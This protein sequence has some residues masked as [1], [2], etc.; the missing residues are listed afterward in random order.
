[1]AALEGRERR[2]PGVAHARTGRPL[3]WEQDGRDWP[4]RECSRF[5]HAGGLRWHVQLAGQGPTL[6]LLHGTGAA[7]HSWRALL[8]LLARHFAVIAPDLPGHGFTSPA[9][10]AARSPVGMA[11][12]LGALL[13]QLGS[14]PLLAVGHSAGAALAA[15]MSLDGL[16]APRGLVSLNGAL[17]PLQG[18]AGLLFPPLARTFS[19]LPLLPRLFARHAADSALVTRLL[20][21]TGSRIDA[22]GEALYARLASDPGH[23]R[24]ALDMM[25]HWDLA[26]L[27]H[28]LPLL[29]IPTLLVTGTNDRTVPASQAARL[30]ALLPA[31]R[32]VRL[33]GL[34]HL[35][36]EE[37]PRLVAALVLREARRLNLLARP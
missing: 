4:N 13:A 30:A 35:A 26:R 10:S 36:H 34:G 8:P 25:A 6:L 12:A 17:L 7:T 33:P 5:V 15:R 24:G 1:M 20:A 28:E 37:E 27:H 11:A 32:A 29:R 19:H 22:Q 9:P 23:V 31:A 21:D 16:I 2:V 18:L 3:D 14:R